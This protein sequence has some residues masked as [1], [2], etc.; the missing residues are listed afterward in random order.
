M[1]IMTTVVGFDSAVT[2]TVGRFNIPFDSV[3]VR[4]T[5]AGAL[6]TV[7]IPEA[8]ACGARKGDWPRGLEL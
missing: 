1:E 4:V 5:E 8:D 3:R 2:V 6:I 7:A